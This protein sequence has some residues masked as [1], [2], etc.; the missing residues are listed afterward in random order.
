MFVRIKSLYGQNYEWNVTKVRN[1]PSCVLCP[2]FGYNV[3]SEN[4][5][6]STYNWV[7]RFT[8]FMVSASYQLKG[9]R[10]TPHYRP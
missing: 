9:S 10:I 4:T 6:G 8:I 7:D 5:R 3:T 1:I 2:M